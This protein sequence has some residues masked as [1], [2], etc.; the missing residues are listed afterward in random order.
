VGVASAPFPFA[1]TCP[2]W[3]GISVYLW[4]IVFCFSPCLRASVVGV[5]FWQFVPFASTCPGEAMDSRPTSSLR[6]C[7]C[8]PLDSVYFPG[9]FH[10]LRPWAGAFCRVSKMLESNY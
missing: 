10:G 9:R 2:G 4:Q 5:L 1:F 7:E 6:L 3:P 8:A